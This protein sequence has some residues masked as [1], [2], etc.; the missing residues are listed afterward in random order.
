MNIQKIIKSD[1]LLSL[2]DAI[3]DFCKASILRD[4]DNECFELKERVESAANNDNLMLL[5]SYFSGCEDGDEIVE[6]L[7]EF[8][9]NCKGFVE[10]DKE[11]TQRIT[12]D[13]FKA[14]LDECES[15]CGLKSCIEIEHS[16][17]IA[18]TECYSQCREFNL[19]V[20]ENNINLI[21]PRVDIK[22]DMKKYISEDLGNILF[23]VLKTRIESE[24][25]EKEM[26]RYIPETR[27]SDKSVKQNFIK[28]F[29]DV[30]LHKERKPGIYPNYDEHMRRVIVVEFFKRLIM[31]YMRE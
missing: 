24:Y 28:Y 18:E 14:V 9:S 31:Q 13:E 15:K 20:K 22:T 29:Y 11:M 19:R 2:V 26:H 5:S 3:N 16:L 25:I 27:K 8:V 1:N 17:R 4:N 30:V 12:K 23:C 10:A 6:A 21:L 7:Y